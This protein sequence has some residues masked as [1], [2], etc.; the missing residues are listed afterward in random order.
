MRELTV[1]SGVETLTQVNIADYLFDNAS[2]HP[3]RLALLRKS[4]AVWN[5]VSTAEFAREVTALANG[6]LAAGVEPGDRVALMSRTR[7]EW[8][9]ADLA[10]LSIGAVVVPVY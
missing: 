3:D 1:A 9:L 4:D 10:L 5:P 8:T 7:Y 2:A 6:L